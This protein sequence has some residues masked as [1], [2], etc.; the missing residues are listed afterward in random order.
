MKDPIVIIGMHRSGTTMI[1]RMLQQLGL[2]VGWVVQENLEAVFFVERNEKLMNMC[3]GS[4]ERPQPIELLLQ[5]KFTRA[6]VGEQLLKDMNSIRFLS[7]MGP[8]RYLSHRRV[9]TID[10][11]WGWKDPRNTFLLP[12]WLD[13]FPNARVVHVYRNGIDVARSLAKREMQ[14]GGYRL[15]RISRAGRFAEMTKDW[16]DQFRN[17]SI[18]LSLRRGWNAVNRRMTPLGQYDRFARQETANLAKAFELW[19]AYVQRST[20][21]VE[22][23]PNKC[24]TLKYE[25]FLVEPEKYLETLCGFCGLTPAKAEVQAQ[26]KNVRAD[27]RHTFKGDMEAVQLYERVR[28]NQ[29]MVKFG[30]GDL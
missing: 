26:C 25:D 20:D 5:D 12:V 23:I 16:W 15:A 19:C 11:P 24:L 14:A 6:K 21:M 8:G 7:Y 22:S 13:L 27:R 1:T 10:F 2:H 29:W 17:E 28:A 9:Q 18:L 3:G 30:Y 4:W